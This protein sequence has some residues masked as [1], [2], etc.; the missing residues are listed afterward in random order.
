MSSTV[1]ENILDAGIRQEFK[2]IFDQRGIRKRQ[3]AL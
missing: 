3:K 1:E 2:R